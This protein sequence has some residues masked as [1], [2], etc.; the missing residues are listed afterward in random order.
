MSVADVDGIPAKIAV[1]DSSN[2]ETGSLNLEFLPFEGLDCD[3]IV[4]DLCF[5]KTVQYRIS[6]NTKPRLIGSLASP[7]LREMCASCEINYNLLSKNEE[8]RLVSVGRLHTIESTR[9][10][11]REDKSRHY[12]D[13]LCT[14]ENSKHSVRNVTKTLLVTVL[15]TDDN[16]PKAQEKIIKINMSSRHVVKVSVFIGRFNF[17]FLVWFYRI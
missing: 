2:K 12:L 15:D 17:I 7:F 8:F 13:V 9:S 14:V 11:D 5:W 16:P 3:F 4:E 10:L 6:E 1:Q